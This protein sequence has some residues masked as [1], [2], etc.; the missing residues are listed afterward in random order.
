M[1][2]LKKLFRKIRSIIIYPF[3][4]GVFF[5]KKL[6]K[7]PLFWYDCNNWGDAL[8]PWLVSMLSG[9]G[10][11]M[12]K[13]PYL[14]KY[15]VIG[16]ILGVAN[17]HDEVWGSGF[18]KENET[19]SE[20]PHK[21]H[22]VRGPLTRKALLDSGIPCPEVYGDP[23]LLLPKF[24]NPDIPKIHDVGVIPHYVEKNHPW[25]ENLRNQAGVNVLDI[26]SGLEEF[27]RQVKSCRVIASSSLHGLICADAYGIPNA[28]IKL[29]D[30]VIGGDFKF[31]DYR[32]SIGAPDPNPLVVT[33]NLSINEVMECAVRYE[34]KLDL[35][36]LMNSCPFL[37]KKK[38][39]A[40]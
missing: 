7:V 4:R 32:L 35:N 8:N 40:N 25:V 27:V 13:E 9:K 29:T 30:E 31:R 26:E 36:K 19:L 38:Y 5:F 14:R 22:A 37:D 23:A 33:D 2:F 17:K 10:V 15:L 12:A 6:N 39:A 3:L 1:F 34:V 18:I 16:S 21:I 20:G 28:W 11:V 24:F